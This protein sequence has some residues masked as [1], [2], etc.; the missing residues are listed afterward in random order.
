M[1]NYYAA[2]KRETTE[3]VVPAVVTGAKRLR[4]NAFTMPEL[5]QA[6]IQDPE[7]RSDGKTSM[8][9]FGTHGVSGTLPSAVRFTEHDDMLEAAVGSTWQVGVPGVGIDRLTPGV[10]EYSHTLEIHETALDVSTLT[11]GTKL[12]GFRLRGAPDETGLL[13][14]PY[15]GIT[16]EIREGVAAPFYTTPTVSTTGMMTA[17]RAAITIGGTPVL[18]LTAFDMSSLIPLSL[19][20]VVG[21]NLSPSVYRENMTLSGT[22]SALRTSAARQSAYLAN[23]LFALVIVFSDVAGNTLTFTYPN[24]SFAGHSLPLG[25]DGPSVATLPV[26]GGVVG[27]AELVMIDRN[28]A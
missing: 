1:K 22:L 28:P 19:A 23:T 16:Q 12:G 26:V 25:N 17:N 2:I 4:L 7:I 24:L 15:M 5:T 14:Y 6:Q 3:G 13:E 8:P 18:N 27:S 9:E 10:L 11:K 21:S 20:K